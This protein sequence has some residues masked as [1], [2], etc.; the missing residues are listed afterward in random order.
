MSYE[1]STCV[2]FRIIRLIRVSD[3]IT[4]LIEMCIPRDH[5][6]VEG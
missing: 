6:Y 1:I 5:Y 3:G 4:R 2:S